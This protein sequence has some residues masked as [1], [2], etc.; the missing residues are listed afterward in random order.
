MIIKR[1]ALPLLTIGL[2]LLSAP[3]SGAQAPDNSKILASITQAL[4]DADTAFYADF[5]TDTLDEWQ[6]NI[7][8]ALKDYQAALDL[9]NANKGSPDFAKDPDLTTLRT[10]EYRA[11]AGKGRT[12]SR[13]LQVLSTPYP[14][15]NPGSDL[16]FSNTKTVSFADT[17][18]I[19]A[20]LEAAADLG[21]T[22]A[23][24]PFE[25]AWVYAS[26]A[27]VLHPNLPQNVLFFTLTDMS[28]DSEYRAY[29]L[30]GK[31]AD[32]LRAHPEQDTSKFDSGLQ[33]VLS[34]QARIAGELGRAAYADHSGK[35]A[36]LTDV[37]WFKNRVERWRDLIVEQMASGFGG[38]EQ[39]Y[40]IDAAAYSQS[41]QDGIFQDPDGTPLSQLLQD[42]IKY[43]ETCY[44]GNNYQV[45]A[46]ERLAWLTQDTT[47]ART[48][49]AAANQ[50]LPNYLSSQPLPNNQ[51]YNFVHFAHNLGKDYLLVG[52]PL[53]ALNSL[54]LVET[55]LTSVPTDQ[56]IYSTTYIHESDI[57]FTTSQSR[58]ENAWLVGKTLYQ[59]GRYREA[60]TQLQSLDSLIPH[61]TT[62]AI[63]PAAQSDLGASYIGL[64]RYED[65]IPP[66]ENSRTGYQSQ[67]TAATTAQDA[68]ATRTARVGL[69]DSTLQLSIP[70]AVLGRTEE[71]VVTLEQ[72]L[73]EANKQDDPALKVNT[74]LRVADI[75]LQ[76]QKDDD[77]LK[78]YQAAADLAAT[79][80]L[81]KQQSQAL[82]GVGQIFANRGL[83]DNARTAVTQANAAAQ[84]A[85]DFTSQVK[86][87]DTL[88]DLALLGTPDSKSAE[89]F[90]TQA[91][92]A[93]T[94]SS[95]PLLPIQP[96]TSLGDVQVSATPN[97]ALLTYY[98]ALSAAL[99][100]DDREAQARLYAR[101]ARLLAAQNNTFAADSA[102]QNAIHI[103]ETAQR[104]FKS[105]SLTSQF[106]A[107]YAPIYASY[108]QFLIDQKRYSDAFTISEQARARAFLDQLA[109]G[110]VDY[111]NSAAADLLQQANDLRTQ[112]DSLRTL[113]VQTENDSQST[114]DVK[115][116]TLSDLNTS[117]QTAEHQ[118]TDIF[119]RLQAQSPEAGS[120]ASV[121]TLSLTNVQ[122]LLDPDTTVLSYYTA[123]DVTYAFL[124]SH[125]S[126]NAIVLP[127]G[128]SL[129]GLS[130]RLFRSDEK[131]AGGLKG[132]S[133]A[134]LSPLVD[135]IKTQHVIVIP[136]NVLNYIPFAALPMPDGSL[137][138]DKFTV[139]YL[140]SASTLAYLATPPAQP[141][142]LL[143]LGNPTAEGLPPLQYSEEEVNQAVTAI[144][145][146]A[147]TGKDA[148]LALVQQ[149]ATDAGIFYVAAHGTFDA[150][151]P[152]FSALH[153]ASTSTDSGLLEAY[154]I[155]SLDLTQRTQLVV[156]SAC[157]TAV[158]TLSAG[159]EFT[160]LNRAFLY[161]GAPS[162]I[163]TLWT[164][165]DKATQLLMTTFFQMRAKGQSTAQALQSAQAYL[166]NY[167]ENGQTPYTSPYYWAA[168]I[169]TGRD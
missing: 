35:A 27:A 65:A 59:L 163:A 13:Q 87:L 4:T 21:E 78:D 111:H 88:G 126:F 7:D 102:Y 29:L 30:F 12:E 57:D 90:Y 145:G 137:F 41:I 108:L 136:H 26:W 51:L 105:E 165:D 55:T 33:S 167:Q 53:Q 100:V 66:L 141:G 121:Q 118:Y 116:Q 89:N 40:C 19:I 107:N 32:V 144:G 128:Q 122:A 113:Q 132:L 154:K 97:V 60:L 157:D 3:R 162:V 56:P 50:L 38:G 112:I 1:I 129:L 46:Q 161:A 71:A 45:T 91:L 148:T 31:A 68:D 99:Q 85:G 49:I 67:L 64:N 147:F 17:Q 16:I 15:Q 82:L 77:A 47:L 96:L 23:T 37:Q 81:P 25:L 73:D 109:V 8:E 166:R 103:V 10:D 124:I 164:V 158:G 69:I 22:F 61:Y 52:Q 20:D 6:T 123:D 70:L 117:L 152:L 24:P 75:Y 101:V 131:Q 93:A 43:D 110:P 140:P 63:Y 115:K 156:L 14:A 169:L 72:A 80:K 83:I 160:G 106:A 11:L 168:F 119:T 151:S 114:P 2:L 42:E 104:G 125:D 79:S 18:P 48:A 139:S 74:T 159:D 155:Y 138:G 76:L 95:D 133:A 86:A 146:E 134:I 153:L 94:T 130:V 84:A 44:P 39:Y 98:K 62:N 142:A 9:V 5:S 92:T 120:L 135:Q 36:G 34:D 127:S 54:Q 58:Y 150:R 143:A 28:V 149:K